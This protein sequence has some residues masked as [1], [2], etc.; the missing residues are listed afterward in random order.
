MKKKNVFIVIILVI[1]V[2]LFIILF[3]INK[4][5]EDKYSNFDHYNIKTSNSISYTFS[6]TDRKDTYIVSDMTKEIPNINGTQG[7]LYKISDDDY[8][9]LDDFAMC[10]SDQADSY[11]EPEYTYFYKDYKT[12]KDMLFITRC[13]WPLV[14]QYDLDGANTKKKE[15]KF[16]TT[17]ISDKELEYVMI[18]RIKKVEDGYI[19]LK[20]NVENTDRRDINIKCSL[21]N[22]IC[23]EE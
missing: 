4:K 6:H 21:E 23:V 13:L 8:I 11:L 22:Y 2:I 19:Y 15:L 20:A 14:V 7:L 3:M 17:Q 1:L 10:G 5:S 16:D 12:D 9:L 18:S